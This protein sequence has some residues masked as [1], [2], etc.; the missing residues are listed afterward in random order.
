[1]LDK[2]KSKSEEKIPKL[3]EA[4]MQSLL[5]ALKA[6]LKSIFNIIIIKQFYS[7][8]PIALMEARERP[9]QS[10]SLQLPT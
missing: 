4:S 8:S 1:M 2:Q 10:S 3:S 6:F 7:Q 9:C 5:I